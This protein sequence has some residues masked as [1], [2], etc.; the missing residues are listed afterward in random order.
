[1]N[2]KIEDV[3]SFY[4]GYVRKVADKEL[5]QALS[6]SAQQ[7]FDVL[8]TLTDEQSLHRY[9]ENKWSI[10]DIIQHLIDAERVFCYRAMRFSRG[11]VTPLEGFDQNVYVIEAEADQRPLQYLM[12]ELESTRKTTLQF[13]SSLKSSWLERK[14][15]ASG[16]EMSV[17]MLGFIISGHTIN[18]LEVIQ[19]RYL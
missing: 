6:E 5:M 19:Q 14:A 9:E 1:M 8:E 2:F 12:E 16:V 17:E 4:Q 13:F 3:P 18:H 7:L 15:V 10:R 11:D